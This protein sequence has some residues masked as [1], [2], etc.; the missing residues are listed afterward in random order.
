VRTVLLDGAEREEDD[1][2][3]VTGERAR[4]DPRAVRQ[5]P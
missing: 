2:A 3:A 1:D 5:P 4:L